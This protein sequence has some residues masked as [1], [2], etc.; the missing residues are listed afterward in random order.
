MRTGRDVVTDS[1]KLRIADS[2]RSDCTLAVLCWLYRVDLL[3]CSCGSRNRPKIG[4][5][6]LKC[7]R[8]IKL[9]GHQQYRIVR[10]IVFTIESLQSF[11][12]HIFDVA[13]RADWQIRIVMPIV[14]HG[15]NSFEYNKTRLILAGFVLV[16]DNGHLGIKIFFGDE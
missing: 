16:A 5:N 13:A 12:R 8:W 2:L 14:S 11:N 1:Y 15:K 10:L 3:Q 9:P 7:L 4:C 6:E